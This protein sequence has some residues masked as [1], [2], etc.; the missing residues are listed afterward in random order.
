M[1]IRAKIIAEGKVHGVGY[2]DFVDRTAS[3]LGLT[4]RVRNLE[5]KS[6]EIVCEGKKEI[7]E[8][9]LKLI[10]TEKY[11]IKVSNLKVE[12]TKSTNEFIDFQV[13]WEEDLTK[14]SFE[15]MALAANYLGEV[16]E[17]VE[18]VGSEVKGLKVSVENVGS[19][20]KGLKVSVENV[21]SE[22]KGLKVS[23][24]NVGSEVK[25]LRFETQK[26]FDRMDKKY[27]KI[28]QTLTEF[29]VKQEVQH[30]KLIGELRQDRKESR[31]DMKSLINA[32]LDVAKK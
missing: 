5:N 32:V 15:R 21:G 12:Y 11:P 2:R 28:S 24:E 25:D 1:Q 4:G 10:K 19:E 9:F 30:E 14:A 29:I 27:D 7:I 8:N 6:V 16:K 17:S 18:N 20:V 13:V 3:N 26:N 31:E 23:V 22:V